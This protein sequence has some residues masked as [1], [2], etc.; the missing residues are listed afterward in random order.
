[1]A[2][3][4]MPGWT[5]L[6]HIC[7]QSLTILG[8]AYL[9]ARW[10]SL[11]R[12]ILVLWVAGLAVD[13]FFGIGLHFHLQNQDLWPPVP[14]LHTPAEKLR[15]AEDIHRHFS[16]AYLSNLQVKIRHK[17]SFLSDELRLPGAALTLWLASLF[18]FLVISWLAGSASWRKRRVHSSSDP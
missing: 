4:P 5:G 18:M 6:A 2:V 13:L 8:L 9:A 1:M 16:S 10:K 14:A 3:H 15:W 11:P 17:L 7:L 12:F